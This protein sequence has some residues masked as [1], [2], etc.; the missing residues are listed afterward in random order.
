VQ[1]PTQDSCLQGGSFSWEISFFLQGPRGESSWCQIHLERQA[2]VRLGLGGEQQGRFQRGTFKRRSV[3]VFGGALMLM[4]PRATTSGRF[5]ARLCEAT[6]GPAGRHTRKASGPLHSKLRI[7]PN[8][9]MDALLLHCC[10]ALCC[11]GHMA[12][13]GVSASAPHE[14]QEVMRQKR[15][16]H[17]A[18]IKVG[19][20]TSVPCHVLV[21]GGWS[22]SCA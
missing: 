8:V 15:A 21:R 4:G 16:A 6:V 9:S 2:L 1:K 18:A 12:I 5:S 20:Y 22:T 11:A 10:A 13:P 17:A 19:R 3:E 14:F 7:P